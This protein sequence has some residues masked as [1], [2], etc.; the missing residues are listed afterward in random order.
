[1]RESVRLE[2]RRR[3]VRERFLKKDLTSSYLEGDEDLEEN[4]VWMV[5]HVGC[6]WGL[7]RGE[8]CVCACECVSKE[9]CI[10]R[11]QIALCTR[12]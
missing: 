1:M 4:E 5:V 8:E 9:N 7:E 11:D 6:I 10:E 3:R 2:S 12:C